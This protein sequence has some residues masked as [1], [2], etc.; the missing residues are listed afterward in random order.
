LTGGAMPR[1]EFRCESCEKSF[2]TTLTITERANLEVK[3]PNCGS[4]KVAPQLTVFTA[5]TA[6][7]G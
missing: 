2:E 3:C 6:R 5:R 7:K 4:D 1:Y